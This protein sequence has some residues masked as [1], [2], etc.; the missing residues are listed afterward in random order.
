[1]RDRLR[2]LPRASSLHA[3]AAGIFEYVDSGSP[4][5][6]V[7]TPMGWSPSDGP[8]GNGTP[9]DPHAEVNVLVG[10]VHHPLPIEPASL[11]DHGV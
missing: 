6:E 2:L 9:I 1:M 11:H 7:G 4:D 5:V 8:T 3:D 10:I